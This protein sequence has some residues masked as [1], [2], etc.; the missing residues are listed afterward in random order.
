MSLIE[1]KKKQAEQREKR[2]ALERKFLQLKSMSSGMGSMIGGG[3]P[4]SNGLTVG[5]PGLY[6][7]YRLKAEIDN[8]ARKR[9]GLSPERAELVAKGFID[10]V[11]GAMRGVGTKAGMNEGTTTAG[12]FLTPDE[13]ADDW[14]A[15]VREE[16]IA[17]QFA[18]IVPMSSDVK[19]IAR[20]DATVFTLDGVKIT[21]EAQAATEV[22]PTVDRTTLTAQRMDGYVRVTNEDLDDARV[23]GGFVA[24]LLD[25]FSEAQGQKCDSCVFLGTGSPMSGVFKSSGYSQVFG[26]GSSN[27]SELLESDLRGIVAKVLKSK[28]GR[29]YCNKSV[30]WTVIYNLRD[31]QNRPLFVQSPS[32]GNQGGGMV[33]GYPVTETYQAPSTSA[34]STG[35]ILFG[36]LDGVVIGERSRATSLFVDPYTRSLSHETIFALFS[37]FAFAQHQ[38]LKLGRIVTAA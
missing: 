34:A 18:R 29:W 21:T 3:G 19:Y 10:W 2:L 20:E 7:G 23:A 38:P 14:T 12:G 30:L 37:R 5:T 26:T 33:W 17:L 15:Y 25:Q 36:D 1:L 24:Q 8:L 6:R 35:F 13:F 11:D 16:S 32:L 27:F 22:S 4:A 9:S 28:R 31:S